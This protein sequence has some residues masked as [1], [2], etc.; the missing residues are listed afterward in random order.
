MKLQNLKKNFSSWPNIMWKKFLS[1]KPKNTQ[2]KKL[3]SSWELSKF[4]KCIGR[5]VK[6]FSADLVELEHVK[7]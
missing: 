7:K 2:N 3:I 6:D 5:G 1:L 4:L